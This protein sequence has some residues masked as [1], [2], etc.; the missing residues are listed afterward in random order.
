MNLE[1]LARGVPNKQIALRLAFALRTVEKHRNCLF[2]K[3]GVESAAEATRIWVL[4]NLE[5]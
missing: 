3:L 2:T 1:L 4:A 5:R